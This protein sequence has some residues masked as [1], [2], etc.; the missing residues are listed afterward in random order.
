MIGI[1]QGINQQGALILK[2][3]QGLTEVYSAEIED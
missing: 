1:V 3:E 2:T